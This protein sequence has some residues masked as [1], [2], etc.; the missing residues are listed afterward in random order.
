MLK[1][2]LL[3]ISILL[4]SFNAFSE[5]KVIGKIIDAQNKQSIQYAVVG[6]YNSTNTKPAAGILSD[7]IGHFS[8]DKLTSGNYDVK[9]DLIGYKTRIL[10]NIVLAKNATV[11]LGI[12]EVQPST[13]SLNE[14]SVTGSQSRNSIKLDKQVFKADQFEAAKG[15]SAIDVLKNMPSISVNGEGEIRLRGSSG[16]LVLVN[17]KPVQTDLNTV[18]SQIPANSIGNV[19]IIT[20]PSA[21]YDADG[22]S[23]IIN[24]TTKAATNEGLSF[25]VNGQYGLPSVNDFDNKVGPVRNGADFTLTYK[26]KKW[27]ISAGAS[28]QR[29]DIAGRREGDVYTTNNGVKTSFPSLGE[30]SFIKKNYT[31]R[32]SASYTFNANNVISAGLYTAERQQSRLADIEYNNT[33]INATTGQ[34]LSKFNYFNSNLQYKQGDFSLANID[35]THT[36]ANKSTLTFSGLYEYALLDNNTKNRN[37]ASQNST[38]TLGYV[39]NTGNSPLHGVR[40]KIDYATKIGKG[41]LESGYQIRSQRQTG[42]Y[43]YQNA[44]LGTNTFVIDPAYSANIEILNQIHAVYSQYSGKVNNLEYLGGLRYEYATRTFS[45]DKFSTP[46]KLTLS[47]LFPSANI[48]YS[49]K[50][51]IRL[52]AGFSKRIQRS[53]NNELNPYPERE[54]SETMEQGDPD[55]LP[56]IVN[57]TELGL[58]K[59]F[60]KGSVYVTLY[61]QQINNVVNRVNSI[62]NDSILN[63]VYTNAGKASLWGAETG[64]NLKPARWWTFY[65]GGNVYDYSIKGSLTGTA[66]TNAVTVNN[67]GV[68]YSINTNQNFQLDKTLSLQLSVNYLSARP[69]A[70]GQDS[71]FISPNLSVKK[72]F[73]KG[74]LT[75]L[76]QWQNIGLGIIPSNEQRITTWGA[77]FY[78]TTNYIQEKDVLWFSLSYNFKQLSKKLKLPT[79]EFGEREF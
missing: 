64:I 66:F 57:L 40:G 70:I 4:S 23:G 67:S 2:T 51:D 8:L 68:A 29:N 27:D 76:V 10:K 24:I 30:R 38:D 56:E 11:E 63:R 31:A 69:T 16:F 41:K 6:I 52:K 9:I 12:I 65:L 3:I 43:S 46:H 19:E 7:S 73:L 32:V 60:K 18:L 50:P 39:Y 58:V 55:I 21:K 36:F 74:N 25:T 17:G 78:T 26:K 49:I 61:N 44:I 42:S 22:K 77:N 54:H 5:S 59:D 34:L 48:L 79:S 53:T 20:S 45:A 33:K 62:F 1:K 37:L 72:T 75:A 13:V 15:G 14:V 47:N 71:R 28:Y 35:Y